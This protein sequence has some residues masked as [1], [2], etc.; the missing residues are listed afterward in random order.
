M[1]EA[2]E[3]SLLPIAKELCSRMCPSPHQAVLAITG[4]M[5]S[6]KST[7]STILAELGA[8]VISADVLAREVVAPGSP[9]LE[10]IQARFGSSILSESGELKRAALAEI[11]FSDH[12]ALRDLEAITHP[13][14]RELST[15]RFKAAL[16]RGCSLI[17]YDCPLLFESKLESLGFKAILLIAAP[18]KTCIARICARDNISEDEARARLAAQLPIEYKRENSDII[19]END[20]SIEDL[21]NALVKVIEDLASE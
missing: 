7:A 14:I 21:R 15:D 8:D 10:E 5:G 6:G 17:V 19:I 20:G 3:G 18:E 12:S 1:G 11:V 13:R 4:T 16:E 2:S 9:A